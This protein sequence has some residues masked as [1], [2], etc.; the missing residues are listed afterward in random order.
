MLNCFYS[1]A[2]LPDKTNTFVSF[3]SYKW[4]TISF[5]ILQSMMFSSMFTLFQSTAKSVFKIQQTPALVF[6]WAFW[7]VSV[8]FF[9]NLSPA[10][11]SGGR[12]FSL[13]A[14]LV[15]NS[16]LKICLHL[17]WR[18]KC[19]I[20]VLE[21]A[22]CWL[23]TRILWEK[24]VKSEKIGKFSIQRSISLLNILCNK[25]F[26]RDEI[27]WSAKLDFG[28]EVVSNVC[29]WYV[30][31]VCW[32]YVMICAVNTEINRMNKNLWMKEIVTQKCV[33][34]GCCES[35]MC[36]IDHNSIKT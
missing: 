34:C 30:A 25:K 33:G 36:N 7:V 6:I 29:M 22:T 16:I 14:N 28:K 8:C 32:C 3:F 5:M 15:N 11:G 35:S 1:C 4:I 24:Q 17:E 13:V 31:L 26:H 19:W 10:C 12:V 20:K 18:D 2:N 27:L 9:L 21:I 23:R